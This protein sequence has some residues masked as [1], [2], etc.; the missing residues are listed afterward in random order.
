MLIEQIKLVSQ[1]EIQID[2]IYFPNTH[3]RCYCEWFNSGCYE[4]MFYLSLKIITC[5][6][7]ET[8]FLFSWCHFLKISL[9]VCTI[10][11]RLKWMKHF[12][13]FGWCHF[14]LSNLANNEYNFMPVNSNAVKTYFFLRMI[15]WT[16]N[17][18]LFL[19]FCLTQKYVIL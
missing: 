19:I 5:F 4:K 13:F 15:K 10:S 17:I 14:F 7:T 3:F 9:K 8:T 16:L 6:T 18:F 11:C 1:H 12:P 2:H